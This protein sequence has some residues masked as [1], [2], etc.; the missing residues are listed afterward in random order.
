MLS[1]LIADDEASIRHG[2]SNAINWESEQIRVI[3]EGKDGNETF[4]KICTL[5]PDIVITD[6]KMPG[7]SGLD[8][9]EKTR[10]N[11]FDTYFI[12]LSGYDDFAFAQR[13][14]HSQITCYLLKP[15]KTDAL[16]AEVA[17]IRTEITAKRTSG[18]LREQEQF[19]AQRSNH[20]LKEQFYTKLADGEFHHVNEISHAIASVG[21]TP[22]S[23]PCAAVV[24][25]FTLPAHSDA[26]HFSAGDAH[27]FKVALRNVLNELS[28]GN[29][30]LEFYIDHGKDVG[31]LLSPLTGLQDFLL[32]CIHTMKKISAL[33]LSVGIGST[34]ENLLDVS[35]SCRVAAEAAEYHMYESGACLFDFTTL[36]S[37]QNIVPPQPPVMQKLAEAVVADNA[38]AIQ[39]ELEQFFA[40][41]LYIPMPPPRYV[42][43]MCTYL[44][45]DVS[46]R[47]AALLQYDSPLAAALWLGDLDGLETLSD[48]RTFMLQTLIEAAH[49]IQKYKK[50][51]ILPAIEIALAYI[52]SHVF[53]RL[54]VETVAA[55]VHLSK[56]HFAAL[57]KKTVGIT[58]QDYILNC[59][60][61][62]AKELLIEKK[63][64]I[65]EIADR[66]E[67]E[68]YRSFSRAFKRFAGCS[69][70]EFQHNMMS[71]HKEG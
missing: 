69:P 26:A 71:P 32:L 66:L 15:V 11:G 34:A 30:Q 65:L 59:K 38:S 23:C 5:H 44:M 68:D 13:A 9:I 25:R 7:C 50:A 67:Y 12:I 21:F 28:E 57:F 35:S 20:V 53:S 40:E 8:L 36:T 19:V 61:E 33:E 6:I 18:A 48:I 37:S 43:G 39:A 60:L 31:V 47:A 56:S 55:E 3:G 1:L 45:G 42:R 58:V 16:L 24:F 10:A 27:L 4:E 51:P 29:R 46:K 49:N 63:M 64:T 22:I 17:R 2:L 62:K 70:T 41:I 54:H 14:I 52:H